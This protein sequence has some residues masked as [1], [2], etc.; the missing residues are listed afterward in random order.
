MKNIRNLVFGGIAALTFG[1]SAQA[2]TIALGWN[3]LS[4][5]DVTFYDGHWHGALSGPAAYLT[6]DGNN[7]NFTG[8]LN[9]T[10]VLSGLDGAI[11]NTSYFS[12][13]AGSLTALGSDDNFLTVTVSGLT[14][15]SHTFN[16]SPVALT[17][18]NIP[19]SNGNI[20]FSLP[21]PPPP[22]GVPDGGS[23]VALLGAAMAFAVGARRK[24]IA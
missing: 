13:S 18:W 15:G 1:L 4:N 23:T 2:H 10:P 7:Y 17:S 11:F 14:T 22:S 21:P 3:V 24:F 8:V 5:G 16:A 19:S 20:E 6:I 12:Y 9:N